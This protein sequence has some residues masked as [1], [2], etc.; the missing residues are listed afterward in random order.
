MAKHVEPLPVAVLSRSERKQHT[1][2]RLREAALDLLSRGQSFP[3]LSLREVT[4]EAGVVPTAFYRHFR[5]L[6]ELGLSLVEEAGLV[7]RRLL[8][9]ARQAGLP[10]EDIIRSSVRIYSAYVRAH[11]R[12]FRLAASERAGGSP[13]LR[14][15]IRSEVAHFVREMA[16]DL[17]LLG[18]RADL[19]TADLELICSLVV[20]TM[21]GAAGEILDLPEGQG[22]AARELEERFVGQLRLIFLGAERW[23]ATSASGP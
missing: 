3:G 22:Q 20:N 12:Q 1:R 19:P 15:A 9:E 6:D 23:R 7:L 16:Q 13:L 11:P 5:D 8:R 4:R 14:Q 10:T 21:L 17:R 18:F 2:E